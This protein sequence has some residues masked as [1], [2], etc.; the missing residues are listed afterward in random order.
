MEATQLRTCQIMFCISRKRKMETKA[1]KE[2]LPQFLVLSHLPFQL[3]S[4]SPSR[5]QLSFVK[6]ERISDSLHAHLLFQRWGVLRRE[7]ATA[8]ARQSPRPAWHHNSLSLHRFSS[9][10]KGTKASSER[11]SGFCLRRKGCN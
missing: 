10:D 8:D 3:K 11:K 1:G 6:K 7:E 9:G 5:I 2:L 4:I